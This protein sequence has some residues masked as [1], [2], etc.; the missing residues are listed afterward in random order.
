MKGPQQWLQARAKGDPDEQKSTSVNL[1]VSQ[2]AKTAII[3]P[4]SRG[5]VLNQRCRLHPSESG[6]SR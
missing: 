5:G 3:V 4:A 2:T 6:A 1:G